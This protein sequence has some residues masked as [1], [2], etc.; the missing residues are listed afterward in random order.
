MGLVEKAS[1]PLSRQYFGLAVHRVCICIQIK[2][3]YLYHSLMFS[4]FI[5]KHEHL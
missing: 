5:Y 4:S 1:V 3:S 2:I